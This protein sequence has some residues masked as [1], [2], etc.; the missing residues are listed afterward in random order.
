M[1]Q[2]LACSQRDARRLWAVGP[3]QTPRHTWRLFWGREAKLQKPWWWLFKP[4]NT[5]NTQP[6]LWSVKWPD[7]FGEWDTGVWTGVLV[8]VCRVW[9]EVCVCFRSV[10]APDP[11]LQI[12]QS[13][14]AL[15]GPGGQS[16][17][18]ASLA[19]PSCVGLG[20]GWTGH[21]S[22]HEMQH[23]VRVSLPHPPFPLSLRCLRSGPAKA[24]V[25]SCTDSAFNLGV[26]C[27]AVWQVKG[28][29]RGQQ[30]YSQRRPQPPWPPLPLSSRAQASLSL[31][32]CNFDKLSFVEQQLEGAQ[33]WVWRKMRTH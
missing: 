9:P 16:F 33:L 21:D 12:K 8:C 18:S 30:R 22:V 17:P 14:L 31:W 2:R 11:L 1:A 19:L 28:K 23:N 7:M 3:Q 27:A 24:A 25:W 5:N 6:L 15:N 4:A 20:C 10:M 29:W 26:V 13:P 32:W